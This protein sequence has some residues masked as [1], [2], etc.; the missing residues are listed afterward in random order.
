V[1]TSA[2]SAAEELGAIARS[3]ATACKSSGSP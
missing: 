3:S 1:P 2:G